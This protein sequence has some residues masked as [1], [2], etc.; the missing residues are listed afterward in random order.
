MEIG[1]V[2]RRANLKDA[3]DREIE[4]EEDS[5]VMSVVSD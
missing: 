1:R 2:A 3:V 5:D 4:V